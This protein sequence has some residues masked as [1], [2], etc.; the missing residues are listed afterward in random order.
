[1]IMATFKFPDFITELLD[2]GIELTLY[3]DDKLGYALNLNLRAKS[4]MYLYSED[5]KWFVDMRYDEKFEVNSLNDLLYCARHGMHG[6]DYVDEMWLKL[7]EK[8]GY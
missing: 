5:S 6:R 8:H 1:M 2:A 3:K 7:M 4:H